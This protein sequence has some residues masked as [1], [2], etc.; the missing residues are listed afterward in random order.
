MICVNGNG[1]VIGG[2]R[3]R[4]ANRAGFLIHSALHKARP[5][6]HAACH[7]HGISGRAWSVFGR[8]LD[9]LVQDSCKLYKSHSVYNAYGGIVF[10]TEEGERIAEALGNGRLCILRNHGLITVGQTVD[11]AAFLFGLG[12]RLC[13]IQL[14]AEAAAA[15]GI[16]KILITDEEAAFNHKMEDDPE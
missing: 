3:S 2:N 10:G 9:M 15:N 12:E 1:D 6:V 4:P 5:D 8:P 7:F 11:E 13:E 16:P 14:K